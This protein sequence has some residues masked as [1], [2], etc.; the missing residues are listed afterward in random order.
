[1]TDS[2]LDRARRLL[3]E[4][5]LDALVI[6][7][8][9]SRRYLTGYTAEDHPPDESAG[10]VVITAD[11][12]V[13]ITSKNNVDWAREEAPGWEV[14]GQRYPWAID[15][16]E[17]LNDPAVKY[18][19]F[20]EEALSVRDFD[21]INRRLKEKRLMKPLEMSVSLIRAIK[22]ER[23]IDILAQAAAVTDAALLEALAQ[24]DEGMTERE[25]QRR[26]EDA[27]RRLGSAGPGFGTIVGSGPN[28]ARPHHASG[29]RR[30]ASGE[31]VVIDMGALWEGYTAD[32]T[33][34]ICLGDPTPKLETVYNVVLDAQQAVLDGVRA[35]MLGK[36]VD[37][38]ARDVITAA[39][40][41]E[42][43]IHGTGH[44]VGLQIHEAP[45]A[46]QRSTDAD[47]IEAGM[48]LTVEPGIYLPDWGG[49]RIEDLIIITEEGSRNLTTAP[50]K[51]A[52][53]DML[54][55]AS[56]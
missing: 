13:L 15:V 53:R 24:L 19:G 31:P 37:A 23:E 8:A 55:G 44:G 6:S 38:L 50:K 18:V 26:I 54:A 10:V 5:S 45:S 16:A 33:R 9:N 51:P 22:D 12:N 17:I 56:Q 41:G 43:Y 14:I 27:M 32:L 39:G 35:G 4:R 20:E 3:A 25:L 28:G 1:M 34:T 52:V 46:G 36:P 21:N 42:H 48:T 49:V 7:N 47:V 11:R 40:Y 30:I 29:A 2:R